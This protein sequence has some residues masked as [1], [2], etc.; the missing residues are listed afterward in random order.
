[1]ASGHHLDLVWPCVSY[2][3]SHRATYGIGIIIV[4]NT[5][6]MGSELNEGMHERVSF[7]AG[8]TLTVHSVLASPVVTSR[9]RAAASKY[10]ELS[11]G[12]LQ[13]PQTFVYSL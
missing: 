5:T 2:F 8:Q 6:G 7:V 13:A 4:T 3:T 12:L 1:M 9:S 10:P 11:E